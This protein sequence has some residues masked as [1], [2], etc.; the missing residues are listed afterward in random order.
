M[1]PARSSCRFPGARAET[2]MLLL[3]AGGTTIATERFGVAPAA[4]RGGA[5]NTV[6]LFPPDAGG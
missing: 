6:C 3:L 4:N 5:E 1:E 2:E